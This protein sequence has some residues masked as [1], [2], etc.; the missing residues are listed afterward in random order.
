M[1]EPEVFT[2]KT[3]HEYVV[4]LGLPISYDAF[5]KRA[6]PNAKGERPLPFE[7]NL[8][9]KLVISRKNLRKAVGL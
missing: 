7:K 3:A 6:E 4:D 5:R 8:F 9:G 2:I 1:N